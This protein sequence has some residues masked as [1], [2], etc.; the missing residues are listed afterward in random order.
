M[1]NKKQRAKL[2]KKL[3]EEGIEEYRLYPVY[4]GYRLKINDSITI[5]DNIK[6]NGLTKTK[7]N[8]LLKKVLTKEKK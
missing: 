4:N 8:E 3:K 6:E 2:K 5:I 1:I 7:M